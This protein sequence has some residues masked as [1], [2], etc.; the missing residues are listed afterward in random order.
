VKSNATKGD[1]PAFL[2]YRIVDEKIQLVTT[3]SPGASWDD[4][5]EELTKVR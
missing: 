1:S 2:V 5:L 4:F 3:G